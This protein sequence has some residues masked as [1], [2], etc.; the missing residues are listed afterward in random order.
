MIPWHCRYINIYNAYTA[1]CHRG[2]WDDCAT[3][4]TGKGEAEMFDV[5]PFLLHVQ[6]LSSIHFVLL[7]VPLVQNQEVTIAAI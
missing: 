3:I 1:E 4:P 6:P 7:V 5:S 2:K